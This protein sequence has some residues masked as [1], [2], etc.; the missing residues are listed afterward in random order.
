MRVLAIVHERDAGPGVFAE[1]AAERGAELD[2]WLISEGKDAPADPVGYH[3]VLTFG[4]S[5]N[6]HQRW[7]H[8]WIKRELDLLSKL[9]DRDIPLLGACLGSQLLAKAAG[10]EVRRSREPEIGWHR[11][12][13]VRDAQ[14]D[15]L[16]GSLALPPDIVAVMSPGFEAFEWH[17]YEAVPPPGAVCLA[18]TV[19]CP[20]AY[21]I[22]ERAWGIQFHA[23]VTA[24]D[25]YKW[26]ADWRSDRDA[27][28]IGLDPDA[29][30]AE[31]EAKIGAWNR[32]GREL[33]GRFLD[34]AG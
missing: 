15:P 25:A 16:L 7:R 26:I 17:S 23:E 9:L 19:V 34:A 11:V 6:V 4:G 24:A 29:L 5:M 18:S 8:R 28:R 2:T 27:V 20:Q 13:V 14:G 1:A 10:G 3:A 22:G 31:T 30:R 32:F 21:R 33:C 12:S